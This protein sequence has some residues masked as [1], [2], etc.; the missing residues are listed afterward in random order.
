MMGP[1]W[2]F[3]GMIFIPLTGWVSGFMLALNAPE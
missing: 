2:G 3:A 1:A